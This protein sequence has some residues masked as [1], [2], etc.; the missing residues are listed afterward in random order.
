MVSYQWGGGGGKMGKKVQGIRNTNGRYKIDRERLRI[1]QEMKKPKNLYVQPMGMNQ[2]GEGECWYEE[3]A[4]QR[5]RK[6]RKKWE[7]CNS[8]IST[9]YLKKI[10]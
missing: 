3:G 7:N 2:A 9:I 8:M 5:E 1:V 10:K 4:G 6:G